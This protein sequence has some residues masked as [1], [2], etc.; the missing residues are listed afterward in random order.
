MKA[1]TS[2]VRAAAFG[3]AAAGSLALPAF[4]A[5]P[6]DD[7]GQ[8]S[9]ESDAGAVAG[10]TVGALLGGPVGAVLGAGAGALLGDRYH[11]QATVECGR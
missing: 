7:R 2:R 10:I 9:K 1:L 4:A 11:R 8:G 5:D 6:A 3:L